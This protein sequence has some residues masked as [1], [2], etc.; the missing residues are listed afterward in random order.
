MCIYIGVRDFGPFQ[1]QKIGHLKKEGG[2]SYTWGAEKG[3]Y[4][5]RTSELC[6]I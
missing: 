4:S 3:G 6:H 1:F 5:A 2:E